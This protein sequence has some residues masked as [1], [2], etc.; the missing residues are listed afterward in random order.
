[1]AV[2]FFWPHSLPQ[3]PQENYQETGGVLSLRTPMDRGPAKMRRVGKRTNTM[4]LTFFMSKTQVDTLTD[5]IE[6]TLL[7]TR[8]FGFTHPRTQLMSE[9]RIVP[10]QDGQMFA[11]SYITYDWYNVQIEFEVLP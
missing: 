4:S 5:F 11:L 1:M 3:A 6:N 10:Q 8:R 2:N 7:G 9:V